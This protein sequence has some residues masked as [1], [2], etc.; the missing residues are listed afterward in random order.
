MPLLTFLIK[1]LLFENSKTLRIGI[2]VE[3]VRAKFTISTQL[4]DMFTA[5]ER[6]L[7]IDNFSESE[8]HLIN[9]RFEKTQKEAVET[10]LRGKS[11]PILYLN[12]AATGFNC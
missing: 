8:V 4:I 6:F 5:F 10:I 9:A 12:N 1:E 7:K 3:M 11:T 2:G